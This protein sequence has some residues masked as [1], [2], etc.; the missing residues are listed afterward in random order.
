M[1]IAIGLVATAIS[2]WV[3]IYSLPG[4]GNP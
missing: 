4:I 3:L 1:E 2:G